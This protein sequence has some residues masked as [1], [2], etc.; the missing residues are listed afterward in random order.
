MGC[1]ASPRRY[2][3]AGPDHSSRTLACAGADADGCCACVPFHMAFEGSDGRRNIYFLHILGLTVILE[4]PLVAMTTMTRHIIATG[5]VYVIRA[6]KDLRPA[7]LGNEIGE[8]AER[9]TVFAEGDQT[10]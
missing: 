10:A 9:R 2:V 1:C 5:V 3:R 7:V 8:G 4:Q 6:C